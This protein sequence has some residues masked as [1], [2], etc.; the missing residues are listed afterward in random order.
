MSQQANINKALR[1]TEAE[2]A[3]GRH[4]L[5]EASDHLL[6]AHRELSELIATGATYL[7]DVQ[8]AKITRLVA[9]C[10]LARHCIDQIGERFD[11]L[12]TSSNLEGK[13]HERKG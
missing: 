4:T 8:R 10:A 11:S 1:L 7:P 6:R 3:Q 12:V 2:A 9:S 5:K 13:I